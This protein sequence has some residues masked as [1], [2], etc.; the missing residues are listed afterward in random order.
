MTEPQ[1]KKRRVGF[2]RTKPGL[3]LI[4]GTRESKVTKRPQPKIRVIGEEERLT[5]EELKRRFS[6]NL[7]LLI[8]LVGLTRKEIADE[9][10][11]THK[12]ILRL[13]SAG[14]SRTDDR[15]AE[16]L[17]K[18]ASYFCLPSVD[19]LWSADLLRSILPADGS[20]AFNEKFRSRLIAE[21]EKRV[22]ER[23]SKSDDE[24]AVLSR[25]LGFEAASPALTG[26]LAEKIAAILASPKAEQFK[27]IIDDYFDLSS[28]GSRST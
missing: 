4:P 23:S 6:E 17:K 20:G 3:K 27:R 18:V 11:V 14:I 21:R 13:V 22:V 9:V 28:A 15:N 25:A 10:G 24:L 19:S 1:K 5:P 26:P 16:Y 8:G 7:D 2:Q 12:L